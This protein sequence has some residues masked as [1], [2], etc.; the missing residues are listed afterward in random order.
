MKPVQRAM[1]FALRTMK[2]VKRTMEFAQRTMKFV[3]RTIDFSMRNIENCRLLIEI[4]QSTTH[5]K[6]LS[7]TSRKSETQIV[8]QVAVNKEWKADFGKLRTKN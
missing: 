2:F 5:I 4:A 7:L 6:E 8:K 1:E 3:Q